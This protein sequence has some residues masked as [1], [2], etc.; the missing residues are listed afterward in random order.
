MAATKEISWGYGVEV[1]T[2]RKLGISAFGQ[3]V[4][5]GYFIEL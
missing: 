3:N 1:F 4:P 5:G 2:L